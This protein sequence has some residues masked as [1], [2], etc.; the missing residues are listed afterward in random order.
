MLPLCAIRK[1]ERFVAKKGST[2]KPL[3]A[4]EE[5]RAGR[6]EFA[7]TWPMIA[8]NTIKQLCNLVR[9]GAR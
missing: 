4:P 2:D 6:F 3:K 9:H 8:G 7:R 5:S 1:R